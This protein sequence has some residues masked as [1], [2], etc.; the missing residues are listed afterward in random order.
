[1]MLHLDQIRGLMDR[2]TNIRNMS[3]IAHGR[4]S[5]TTTLDGDLKGK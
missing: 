2:S 4:F 3:V 5:L 1:M